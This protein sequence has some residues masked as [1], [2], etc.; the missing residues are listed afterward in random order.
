MSDAPTQHTTDATEISQLR[1][2]QQ[3]TNKS[4]EAQLELINN[5]ENYE[6]IIIQEPC[7]DFLNRTRSTSRWRVL[8]PSI[9]FQTGALHTRSVILVNTS[10]SMGSWTQLEIPSA[11]VTGMQIATALGLIRIFNIY[12][13][14]DGNDESLAVVKD[15]VDTHPVDTVYIRKTHLAEK[16]YR[17]I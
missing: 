5:I 2:W 10:V 6:I 14:G 12:N 8:Y 16:G 7:I 17:R 9:H 4:H 1:I 13:P 11:D 15:Y 3:N